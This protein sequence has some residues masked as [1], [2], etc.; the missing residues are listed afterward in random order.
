MHLLHVLANEEPPDVGHDVL[1]VVI[2]DRSA[3]AR[4]NALGSV[5]EDGGDDW[6]VPLR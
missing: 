6:K 1:G 4:A 3:P 2:G 5:D